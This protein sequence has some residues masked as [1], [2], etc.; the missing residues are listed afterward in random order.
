MARREEA[1]RAA[2]DLQRP[3]HVVLLRPLLPLRAWNRRIVCAGGRGRWPTRA[4]TGPRACRP[5]T[6][7]CR[8]T[9]GGRIRPFLLPGQAARPRLL[10]AAVD[11]LAARANLARRDR[12]AA[13]RSARVPDSVSTAVL[14]AW[15]EPAEG[16]REL[17]GRSDGGPGGHGRA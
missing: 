1:G 5:L 11:P 9:G 15:S 17:P 4:A 13:D 10:F 8:G 14:Q 16:H 12:A 6:P 7:H 3:R 2:H